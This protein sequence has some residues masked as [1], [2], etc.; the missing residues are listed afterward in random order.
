M[1]LGMV[2]G[3][4]LSSAWIL[5]DTKRADES[6][7]K[8][9]GLKDILHQNRHGLASA[10]GSAAYN[11][12]PLAIVSL[13]APGTQPE[14]ALADRVRG[15][16]SVAA[17]PAAAVLQGWVPNATGIARV[18]RARVALCLAGAL[19]SALGLF[20]MI[21]SPPLMTW[22][23]HGRITL[24]REAVVLMAASVSAL[25]FQLVLERS[26]LASF[27]RLRVV[28]RAIL[29]GSVVGLPLVGLGAREFD[30]AGALGGALAGLLVC[31]F[32]E[33]RAYRTTVKGFRLSGDSTTEHNHGDAKGSDRP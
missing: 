12:A 19:A 4:T 17:A 30:T 29:V 10:L 26:V 28:S 32:V 23:G 22:L 1:S 8:R 24:P 15:L 20:T 6:V 9:R 3:L 18:R 13:I 5:R 2:A 16:V 31:L 27:G 21:L 7:Q 11:A 25:F 14:F 33:M